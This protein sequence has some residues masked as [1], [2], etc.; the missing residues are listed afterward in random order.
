MP[1]AKLDALL[2]CVGQNAEVDC[3]GKSSIPGEEF[4]D[5]LGGGWC[6]RYSSMP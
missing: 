3:L 4:D 1:L 6:L 2:R 5:A